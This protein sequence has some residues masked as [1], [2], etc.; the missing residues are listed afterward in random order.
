A[1]LEN[2]LL[3]SEVREASE[4]LEKKVRL[5]TAELTE[6]N[7]E[8]GKAL[9][10]LR[11]TQAQLVLS[12]R[13]AGLGLLVAGVAHEINSPTAA[14]RGS[15]EGLATALARV[16]RHNLA[17]RITELVEALGPQLAERPLVTGLTARKAAR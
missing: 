10:D 5:R 15:I 14:I 6:A 7:Q 12:E 1:A 17:P 9:G 3:Y 8:L 4:E 2:A 16:A 13:M 11:E